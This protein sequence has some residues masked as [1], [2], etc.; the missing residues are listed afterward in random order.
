MQVKRHP[1]LTMLGVVVVPEW[2]GLAVWYYS[3]SYEAQVEIQMNPSFLLATVAAILLLGLGVVALLVVA[4][5]RSLEKYLPL[6]LGVL[7]VV[8][9]VAGILAPLIAATGCGCE[10]GT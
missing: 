9:G 2:V 10:E 8:V 1:I 4:T 6:V 7:L 5:T 3:L